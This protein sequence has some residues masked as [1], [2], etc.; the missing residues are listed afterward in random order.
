MGVLFSANRIHGD[1][2]H[3]RHDA[4]DFWNQR[5][6]N[7]Y[8]FG[9]NDSALE[10]VSRE[11]GNYERSDL[12]AVDYF[13]WTYVAFSV[14][15]H[16]CQVA[17]TTRFYVNG[18]MV[19]SAD[20]HRMY[21]YPE[22]KMRHHFGVADVAKSYTKH[23]RGFIY[24]A[25]AR[26]GTTDDEAFGSNCAGCDFCHESNECLGTCNWNHYFNERDNKCQRCPL[27]CKSGCDSQGQCC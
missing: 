1:W 11:A 18:D 24:S 7:G 21:D 19:Y 20:T 6:D 10:Y 16:C 5:D 12:G 9:I 3:D 27:W 13:T 2:D 26:H 25:K 17:S 15:R 4:G 8:Y 22:P 23:Y 14:D